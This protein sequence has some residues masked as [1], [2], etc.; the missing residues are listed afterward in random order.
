MTTAEPAATLL[1]AVAHFGSK[2]SNI[3]NAPSAGRADSDCARL[4]G[5]MRPTNAPPIADDCR[6][7]L[8]LQVASAVAVIGQAGNLMP[9]LRAS[10]IRRVRSDAF[11][12]SVAVFR[13]TPAFSYMR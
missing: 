3:G 5:E 10:F 1:R 13:F 9:P 8:R 12:L 11:S 7:R 2:R 6:A 4:P